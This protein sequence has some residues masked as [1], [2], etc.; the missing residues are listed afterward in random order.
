MKTKY[1]RTLN[2]NEL[3][4]KKSFF[5]F[6]P[7]ATGKSTMIAA[8]L[9][10]AKVYDLLHSGTYN[11][12]IR[13]PSLIYEEIIDTDKIIVIDE[14]QKIPSLLDEV[15][16]TIAKKNI[17]FLLTGSSA[18]KLKRGAANLLAGRAWQAFLYPLTS[19]EITDFNLLQYCNRGGL[20]Q[21]YHS[22]N[23]QE[24]LSNYAALYLREEIQAEAHLRNV[25]SFT[26]F[27]DLMALSN[28][29]EINLDSFAS[30]CGVSPKTIR[31]YIEILEDTLI[32]EQ[33][34]VFAKTKKRKAVSQSK[35]YLFDLGVVN[36][37][38]NRGEIKPKSELFG[39]AVEDFIINEVKAYL[40]Y[41]RSIHKMFYWRSTS[42]HEVDLIVGN[43]FALEIK[44][45][46]L[47]LEKHCKSLLI[48][49][50][51]DLVKN[52][53]IVSCDENLR[54][55][56]NGIIVYPWQKFCADLWNNKLIS[57]NFS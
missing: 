15:H 41:S 33:L 4:D 10:D 3:L 5:L 48:F 55:L 24:E 38:A 20:P 51:E 31:S 2:L 18:R 52:Y 28:G 56:D 9:K 40:S 44:S 13:N 12:L 43:Q 34:H 29:E 32:G 46:S 47:A 37:L 26:E 27:L 50:E 22:P 49:K 8:Q 57:Q 36:I 30:D 1:H 16:R 23:F 17:K 6:G 14:I 19:H 11:K 45:T 54:K 7:R 25:Q 21:V 53:Y 42:Q 39:K 35:F